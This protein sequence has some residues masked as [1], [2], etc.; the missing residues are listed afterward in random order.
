MTAVLGTVPLMELAIQVGLK[1][2][3]MVIWMVYILYIEPKVLHE[4]QR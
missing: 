1:W 3:Y 2:C 4:L